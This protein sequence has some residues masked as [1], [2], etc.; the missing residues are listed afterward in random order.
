MKTKTDAEKLTH[1][2]YDEVVKAFRDAG[3]VGTKCFIGGVE[4]LTLPSKASETYLGTYLN[5]FSVDDEVGLWCDEFAPERPEVA[6]SVVYRH[7]GT[8]DNVSVAAEVHY[9]HTYVRRFPTKWERERKNPAYV[10][11]VL[12][13][14][15]FNYLEEKDPFSASTVGKVVGRFKVRNTSGKKALANMVAK[16]K[17]LCEAFEPADHSAYAKDRKDYRA[18]NRDEYFE[19]RAAVRAKEQAR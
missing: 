2:K 16:A 12:A 14:S 6:V 3:F 11:K 4:L 17:A 9:V 8:A 19:R 1:G 18:E 13:A 15:P 7:N 10:A 5:S